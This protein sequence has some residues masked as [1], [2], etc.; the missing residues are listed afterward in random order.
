MKTIKII[1][2]SLLLLTT[3]QSHALSAAN[4]EELIVQMGQDSRVI[5]MLIKTLKVGIIRASTPDIS[6]MDTAELI[7]FNEMESSLE[8]DKTIVE[9]SYPDYSVMS[10]A[11]K[12]EVITTIAKNSAGFN[13][14]VGCIMGEVASWA[15]CC[16]V[17]WGGFA[18]VKYKMCS[19]VSALT[20]ILAIV[21]A[22]NTTEQ[23]I[24]LGAAYAELVACIACTVSTPIAASLI[25]SCTYGAKNRIMDCGDKY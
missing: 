12:N 19:G 1:V 22:P 24:F 25:T 18:L 16:G 10:V 11:E 2:C 4:K 14:V 5:N 13:D 9:N 20:D 8:T 23:R 15:A 3:L 17:S 21:T 6:Q 7:R